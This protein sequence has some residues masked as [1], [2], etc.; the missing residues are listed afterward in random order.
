MFLTEYYLTTGDQTVLD[1]IREYTVALAKAQSM[2]GTY[3]HGGADNH[4]DGTCH[5]SV[6]PYGPVTQCGL[7]ALLSIMM[8]KKCGVEDPEIDPAIDRANKFFGYHVQKGSPARTR[9]R[10]TR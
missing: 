10:A 7:A 2:F 8:G 9:C 6:P 1:G 3:G 5:G 4:H